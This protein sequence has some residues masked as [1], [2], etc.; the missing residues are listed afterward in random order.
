MSKA[1]EA[2]KRVENR[3]PVEKRPPIRPADASERPPSTPETYPRSRLSAWREILA[4]GGDDRRELF[5]E[6]AAIMEHE[7]ELTREQAEE[8]AGL[9]AVGPLVAKA[10]EVFEDL[11][12][13]EVTGPETGGEK[14]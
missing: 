3:R 2:L 13:V 12:V 4:A 8:R 1:L 14:T 5:E 11:V 7:G 10:I 6:R 9:W